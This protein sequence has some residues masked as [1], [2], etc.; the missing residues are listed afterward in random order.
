MDD[1][2]NLRFITWCV[3]RKLSNEEIL[4]RMEKRVT[5]SGA[6]LNKNLFHLKLKAIRKRL[7]PKVPVNFKIERE[8]HDNVMERASSEGRTL[9]AT[10]SML[11][12]MYIDGKVKL[13]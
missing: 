8:L 1:E 13:E 12:R 6:V 7:N 9:T 10:T 2:E 11:Y 5:E 4:S 3:R